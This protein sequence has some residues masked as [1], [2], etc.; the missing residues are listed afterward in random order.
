MEDLGCSYICMSLALSFTSRVQELYQTMYPSRT[1]PRVGP[2]RFPR[3]RVSPETEF[4][5]RDGRV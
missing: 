4:P 5:L 3:A 2:G 1:R